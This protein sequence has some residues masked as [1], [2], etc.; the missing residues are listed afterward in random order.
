M[1]MK[2]ISLILLGIILLVA[3]TC[4]DSEAEQMV[5][6]Q[7]K[8]IV[9]LENQIAE[10]RN[11]IAS[12]EEEKD[13][14]KTQNEQLKQRQKVE[15]PQLSYS[16]MSL[17]SDLGELLRRIEELGVAQ[18][19]AH[20]KLDESKEGILRNTWVDAHLRTEQLITTVSKAEDKS[21]LNM[22][23]LEQEILSIQKSLDRLSQLVNQWE[24]QCPLPEMATR[25][26]K[27][28]RPKHYQTYIDRILDHIGVILKYL[29]YLNPPKP[30]M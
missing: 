25:I 15:K 27:I 28:E 9:E 30:N 8:R 16:I 20:Y 13:E 12:L 21:Q 11:Q 3:T 7:R 18:V 6:N 14:L 2:I 29:P 5:E 10:L 19:S 24:K 17:N 4:G 23:T 1:A 22:A 26:Y